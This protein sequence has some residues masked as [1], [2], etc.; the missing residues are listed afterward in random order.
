MR[1]RQDLLYARVSPQ[2][3]AAKVGGGCLSE[4]EVAG[5]RKGGVQAVEDGPIEAAALNVALPLYL[6]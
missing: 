2:K 4:G 1:L 5:D 6:H 3:K